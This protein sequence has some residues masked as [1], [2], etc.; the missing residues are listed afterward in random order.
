MW[1][2]I[3]QTVLSGLLETCTFQMEEKSR[4]CGMSSFCSIYEVYIVMKD[5]ELLL[6]LST[7]DVTH[8]ITEY[9]FQN[10]KMVS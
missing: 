8:H 9:W 7:G 5:R 3:R 6:V 4:M 1:E 10:R 2:T